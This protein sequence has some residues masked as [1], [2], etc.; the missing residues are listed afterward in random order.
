MSALDN[1]IYDR[2]SHTWWEEDGFL[3]ILKSALNPAR[4]GYMRRVLVDELQTDLLGLR[5]L[6]IG[7]GGGLL[8]EEFAAL[9][10]NVIGI[11]PSPGSV[12]VAAEH[13]RSR[14]LRIEY[15]Q[16]RGEEL[17]F[18]TGRFDAAFC[19]DVLEHVEDLPTVISEASR[20]LADGGALLYD[21][22]N[23]TWQSKLV[24][25]KLAQEW[26]ATAW[27]DPGLHD[28]RMFVRPSEIEA[29]LQGAGLEVCDRVGLAPANQL[30]AL[31]ALWGRAHG[32]LSYAA[33][34]ERL[35]IRE[36]R[37]TTVSYGG[38]AIKRT[39]RA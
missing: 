11:D 31:K 25:I 3:N 26:R 17:P 18:E 20:V 1:Q 8:A 7:C 37:D 32:K 21:T 14:G 33:M 5:V 19:C 29:Q 23:R 22:I 35:K 15:M 28:F 10:C 27:A 39:D 36:S 4:F 24:M 34:G 2:L 38:Y 30:S 6:D 13:A 16:G 9:G 12:E